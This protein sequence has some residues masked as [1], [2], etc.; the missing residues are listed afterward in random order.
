MHYLKLVLSTA[1][2]ALLASPAMAQD[3]AEEAPII[4]WHPAPE[5]QITVL[6]NGSL[7]RLEW[8]GQQVS[9][10]DRRAITAVQGPDLA[11]ILEHAPGITLSRNGGPGSFTALRVRGS[12]AD[13]LLVL[14][15]GVRMADIAAPGAGF[16]L[17]TLAAGNLAKVEVQRSANSTIW[18][19]QALGGVLHATTAWNASGD[20]QASAEGGSYGSAHANAQA[21]IGAGPVQFALAAAHQRADGFSAAAAGTED[22]GY[23]QN[24]LS[25]RARAELASS[26]SA[27]A[28]T[29][30]ADA[31]VEIDGFPA[32]L[33]S[34]ADTLEWQDTRQ[35]SG[36]AGLAFADGTTDVTASVSQADIE[37]ESFDPVAGT[38]PTYTTDGTSRRA[39]LRGRTR[40]A[41]Q[42][43]FNF[44]GERE[45]VRF[46]TLFDPP[47]RTASWGSYAQFEYDADDLHLAI[48]VRRD[49]HRQFG[50]EWSF[51]ADA[52][53]LLAD[54]LRLTASY[55][56]GFKAPSLFQLLSDYG[57]ASLR[58]ER[59]RSMDA[60]LRWEA[61]DIRLALVAFRRNTRDQIAYDSCMGVSTGICTN[62]PYGT[63]DN[64]EATRAQGI[65]LEAEWQP[66]AAVRLH[67]VYALVDSENRTQGAANQGLPLARRP[68]HAATLSAQWMPV[69]A[70]SLAA[71]L[72]LVSRSF[73]DAFASVPIAGHALGTLR[74]SWDVSDAFTLFGRI[75]NLWDES[76]QTAAG[77]AQAGRAAHMGVR[78]RL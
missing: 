73:D 49:S 63:Y 11:R 68:R 46:A 75:E 54:R 30:W 10:F 36:S 41:E 55:G 1:F 78:Y 24:E 12:E 25:L 65:E 71:D 26:L 66:S 76:Y 5:S 50:G 69:D 74:A 29:R 64:L 13:Q 72:R 61:G 67:G 58:P 51:G 43:A 70:L 15:D 40:L 42:L 37:R 56:E 34:L 62:R 32:P 44:G 39:E 60:G 2:A 47:R 6:A 52:V 4:F 35:L 20:V 14:L 57:N 53:Y 27:F 22:D 17:G 3:G 45:W 9:V 18:G 23:R 38:A 16:D 8:T 33:Y 31:R 21:G 77:Y 59:S 19:S 28:S 7:Q 48:G